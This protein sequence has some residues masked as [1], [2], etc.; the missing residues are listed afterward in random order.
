[1]TDVVG[2]E[3][4]VDA[5]RECVPPYRRQHI[6]ANEKGLRA[7]FDAAPRSVEPAWGKAA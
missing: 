6:E 3:S 5:M 7:G 1:M 2:I 4:L